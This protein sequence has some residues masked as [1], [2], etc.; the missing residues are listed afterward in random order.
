MM[1]SGAPE[2]AT[3]PRLLLVQGEAGVGKSR[4]LRE[5]AHRAGAG[6]QGHAAQALGIHREQGG[7]E[8]RPLPGIRWCRWLVG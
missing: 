3:S 6:P 4:W 5:V 7:G 1:V 2:A 8:G